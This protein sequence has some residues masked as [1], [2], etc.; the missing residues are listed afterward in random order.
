MDPSW[1][2]VFVIH[3]TSCVFNTL[4]LRAEA[5]RAFDLLHSACVARAEVLARS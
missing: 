1:W 3:V 2:H 5:R 4:L